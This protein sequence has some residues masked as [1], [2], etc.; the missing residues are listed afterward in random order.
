MEMDAE[1]QLDAAMAEVQE[2]FKYEVADAE[3]ERHPPV[4][5]EGLR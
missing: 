4:P 3:R 1:A 5:A 2:H